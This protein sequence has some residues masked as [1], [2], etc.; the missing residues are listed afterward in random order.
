M[1]FARFMPAQEHMSL[2]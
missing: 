1:R 2:F